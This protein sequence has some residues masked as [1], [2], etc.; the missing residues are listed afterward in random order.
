V[1]CLLAWVNIVQ[2]VTASFEGRFR[3]DNSGVPSGFCGGKE[4]ALKAL[5]CYS[6]IRRQTEPFTILYYLSI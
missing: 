3:I 1:I 4:D 5:H 6:T 2:E